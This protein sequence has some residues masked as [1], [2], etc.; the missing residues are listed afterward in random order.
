MS[1]AF[2]LGH[3]APDPGGSCKERAAPDGWVGEQSEFAE[4][5]RSTELDTDGPAQERIREDERLLRSLARAREP[6][7]EDR[8]A[9]RE[10]IA[11]LVGSY[12][13]YITR[14]VALKVFDANDREDVAQCVRFRLVRSLLQQSS[15][16]TPF[17]TVVR[18]SLNNE[19]IDYIRRH[20]RRAEEPVDP[21]DPTGALRDEARSLVPDPAS[22]FEVV[23]D[24][25]LSDAFASLA[26]R[27][28]DLLRAKFFSGLTGPEIA[29]RF[30]MTESNVNVRFHR[31]FKK[32]RHLLTSDVTNK[33]NETE[34]D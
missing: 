16:N 8:S 17:F 21:Q 26:Q 9:Q 12:D 23:E 29:N 30:D 18:R 15:F 10:A 6:G 27:D 28:R 14:L 11:K 3:P 32:L 25:R 13:S 20:N 31:A 33:R 19:V 1:L 2:F 34:Y 24:G 7:T 4:N 22:G 5:E